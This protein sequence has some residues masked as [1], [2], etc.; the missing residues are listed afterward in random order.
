MQ[1]NAEKFSEIQ[2]NADILMTFMAFMTFMTHWNVIFDI[3]EPPAFRKYSTCWILQKFE[4]SCRNFQNN[5][6][7]WENF[8]VQPWKSIYSAQIKCKNHYLILGTIYR[9]FHVLFIHMRSI[10]APS[11]YVP[12]R[13]IC[14]WDNVWKSSFLFSN[15]EIQCL[16]IKL[17]CLKYIETILERL[18]L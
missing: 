9:S 7:F 17:W 18:G 16:I 6:F 5:T 8:P 14:P 11:N 15:D 10:H 4:E 3:L 2:R 13:V 1:R 12:C